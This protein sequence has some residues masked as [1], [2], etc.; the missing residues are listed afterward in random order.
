MYKAAYSICLTNKRQLDCVCCAFIN[1]Y[2]KM[3]I[4]DIL[5]LDSFNIL[6]CILPVYIIL[7]QIIK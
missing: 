4:V 6:L 3:L 1:K 7:I 2:K 5:L